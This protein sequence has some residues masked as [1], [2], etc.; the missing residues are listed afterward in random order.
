MDIINNKKLLEYVDIL[1]EYMDILPSISIQIYTYFFIKV[2]V[3]TL[4]T[5][6]HISLHRI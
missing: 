3:N 1:L 2:C 6:K 4:I 5:Q